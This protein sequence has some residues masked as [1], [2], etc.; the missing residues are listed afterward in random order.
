LSSFEL[1]ATA[2][3]VQ[4]SELLR[5]LADDPTEIDAA[6][7]KDFDTSAVALLLEVARRAE[8]HGARLVVHN[9]PAK[10]VQLAQLYGVDELLSLAAPT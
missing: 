4:A 3:L 8:A 5:A 6:A 10:L 7:L 2:T 1:P 9:P